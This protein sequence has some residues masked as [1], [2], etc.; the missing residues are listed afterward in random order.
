MSASGFFL[1]QVHL[2]GYTEGFRQR[3]DQL[4]T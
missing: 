4:P 3:N 2:A 1:S